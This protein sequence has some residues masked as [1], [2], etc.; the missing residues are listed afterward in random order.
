M[1]AGYEQQW[2]G[3]RF[4]ASSGFTGWGGSYEG[5]H[6]GGRRNRGPKGYQRSDDRIKEDVSEQLMR[7]GQIDASEVTVQVQDGKVTLEGTVPSRSMKYALEDLCDRCLGVKEVDNRVRVER[8][9]SDRGGERGSDDSSRRSSANGGSGSSSMQGAGTS[10][11]TSSYGSSTS[12]SSGST[13]TTG[14]S[15][16]K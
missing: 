11:S 2:G 10:G 6:G 14:T 16:T 12:G 4:G 15:R 3:S 5:E 9:G 7:S 13:G 8:S 1:D